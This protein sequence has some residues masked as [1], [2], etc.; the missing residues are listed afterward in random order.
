MMRKFKKILLIFLLLSSFF[1]LS[2]KH[3][4]EEKEK[5]QKVGLL[6]EGTVRDQGWGTKAYTGLLNIQSK[7][8]VDIFYKEGIT[9]QQIAERAI[10]EFQNK[11]V[12]LIFGNSSAFGTFFNALSQK[13]PDIHFVSFNGNAN[14]KNTTSVILDGYS[15][16]FFG[17]MVAGYMTKTNTIGV[18]AAF[19]NESEVQGFADGAKFENKHV[20]VLTKYVH[21]W[22][23]REKASLLLEQLLSQNVD[24]V[25]PTGNGYNLEVIEKTKEKGLYAIGFATDR[26]DLGDG[27]V[28]TS[29]IQDIVKL[30]AYT[31]KKFNEGDL[32]AG[33]IYFGMKDNF[34]SLGEFSEHVDKEFILKINKEINDFKKSG[35][36]PNGQK[37]EE[38]EY[39]NK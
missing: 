31:A 8:D 19:E 16:G 39:D 9:S 3:A 27:N 15:M 24:I 28:L 17:G 30:Y 5:I 4:V 35:K 6:V 33:N 1:L 12:N 22:D 7:Y 38:Y 18:V 20:K 32:S 14:N 26:T 10:E 34:T 36:L 21:S 25:Y 37:V 11:G 23:D 29:T 13:Y 2:C